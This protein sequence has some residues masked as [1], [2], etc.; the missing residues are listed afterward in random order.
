MI[1]LGS[2]SPIDA[3]EYFYTLLGCVLEYRYKAFQWLNLV[4]SALAE[5]SPEVSVQNHQGPLL[6]RVVLRR[7][8]SFT[9]LFPSRGIRR[10]STLPTPP[11]G[12][13]N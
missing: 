13:P 5:V 4:C 2:Q 10:E 9:H 12:M 8:H 7:V 1:I 6:C 11:I 3:T